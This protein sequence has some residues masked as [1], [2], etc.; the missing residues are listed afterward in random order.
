[1][2]ASVLTYTQAK[3]EQEE[4]DQEA[5]RSK[6]AAEAKVTAHLQRTHDDNIRGAAA[7]GSSAELPLAA[8]ISLDASASWLCATIAYDARST[9]HRR[10]RSRKRRSGESVRRGVPGLMQRP[11]WGGTCRF[12]CCT[13]SQAFAS[14]FVLTAPCCCGS[15]DVLATLHAA[16]A[17]QFEPMFP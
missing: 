17:M 2:T 14:A 10:S 6:A 7:S 11:R 1:M 12:A 15:S 5:A 9:L 8:C 13:T 16:Q 4:K 3:K